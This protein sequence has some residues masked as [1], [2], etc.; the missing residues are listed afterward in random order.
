VRYLLH[1]E[2]VAALQREGVGHL[3]YQGPSS[4]VIEPGLLYLQARLGYEVANLQISP[5]TSVAARLP[6]LIAPSM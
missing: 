4:L 6:E 2:L 3:L 5:S 1:T